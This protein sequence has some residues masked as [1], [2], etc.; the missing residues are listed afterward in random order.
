MACRCEE[1]Y[2]QSCEGEANQKQATGEEGVV[3]ARG[4][5]CYARMEEG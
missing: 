3:L 2:C 4:S 5:G 1:G